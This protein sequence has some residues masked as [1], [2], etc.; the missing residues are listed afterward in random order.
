MIHKA[1]IVICLLLALATIVAGAISCRREI[2]CWG[3][4]KWTREGQGRD[5]SVVFAPGGLVTGS[6]A[7][8]ENGSFV[9]A[10]TFI[11]LNWAGFTS[12][13][14]NGIIFRWRRSV[15]AFL[16]SSGPNVDNSFQWS[17]I[18]TDRLVVPLWGPLVLFTIY[19]AMALIRG[20]YRRHRRH[21]KGLCVQCG[22][23]LTGNVSGVC[24]ECGEKV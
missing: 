8:F 7:D 17:G 11:P 16:L 21:R 19:P 24:P 10:W 13:E 3:K 15:D 14:V 20:P 6:R 23:S 12:R 2:V 9:H 4:D 18:I 22:Y 5:G 1:V